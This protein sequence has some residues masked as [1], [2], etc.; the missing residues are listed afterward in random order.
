LC[1]FFALIS[2]KTRASFCFW[3]ANS[4]LASPPDIVEPAEALKKVAAVFN[5]VDLA[6]LSVAVD[7]R[8]SLIS[9]LRAA[10]SW[11]RNFSFSCLKFDGF[12]NSNGLVLELKY[13]VLYRNH[14]FLRDIILEMCVLDGLFLPV[15]DNLLVEVRKSGALQESVRGVACSL[16]QR[17]FD[18]KI[19]LCPFHEKSDDLLYISFEMR[20]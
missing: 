5:W 1:K 9:L 7:F 17:A 14:R 11:S 2:F 19:G 3:L 10:I 13:S 20:V 4:T 15:L 18:D 8:N 12:H 16:S 6:V